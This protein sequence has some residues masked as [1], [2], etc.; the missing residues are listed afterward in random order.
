LGLLAFSLVAASKNPWL[1]AALGMVAVVLALQFLLT[2]VCTAN[3]RRAA[4]G[5]DSGLE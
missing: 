5:D 1:L 2:A 3:L 4:A